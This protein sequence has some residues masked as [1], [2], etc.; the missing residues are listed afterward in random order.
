MTSQNT[1]IIVI[2]TNVVLEAL[3]FD[4]ARAAGLRAALERGT[5][6]WLAT[7]PMRDEFEQVAQRPVLRRWKPDPQGLRRAFNA[8]ATLVD[9]APRSALRCS[10]A[11]DQMFIDLALARGA[12]WLLTRDRALLAL[13]RHA[14]RDS[15]VIGPPEAMPAAASGR[16]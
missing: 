3:L 16:T 13:R 1:P 8:L 15:L 10:D 11:D 7:A 4:D 12:R 9:P 14:A 6:R 2:D 5:W